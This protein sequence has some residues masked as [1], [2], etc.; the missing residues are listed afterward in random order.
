MNDLFIRNIFGILNFWENIDKMKII[1]LFIHSTIHKLT[2]KVLFIFMVLP[3]QILLTI[4]IQDPLSILY[5]Y[6]II[7]QFI[8]CFFSIHSILFALFYALT[9]I[10]CFQ[11][12]FL[13]FIIFFTFYVFT[14]Q[15]NYASNLILVNNL[16]SLQLFSSKSILLYLQFLSSLNDF[17]INS[18]SILLNLFTSLLYPLS[19]ISKLKTISNHNS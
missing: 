14:K 13:I 18:Y 15:D 2:I 1:F 17:V 19:L 8:H 12:I 7:I 3:I 6:S 16:A 10:T 5:L 4:Y 9:S 11:S